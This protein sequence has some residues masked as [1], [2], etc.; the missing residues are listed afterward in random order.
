MT[1]AEA[2]RAYFAAFNANDPEGI[3]ALLDENVVHEI[4][5][6]P[7]E[8]GLEAFRRFK[9]HMD[10][11]YREQI[12]DLQVWEDGQRGAS[13]FTVEGAYIATDA[14]LPEATGQTYTISA[15]A[16]FTVRG[17]KIVKVTSYYNLRGWL[18]A[19]GS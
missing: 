13:E 5:E 16:F 14:P 1:T 4:N 12:L 6:G 19:I 10:R 11:C 18:Q 2:I 17:G 7:T 8:V 9:A 15:A 3:F